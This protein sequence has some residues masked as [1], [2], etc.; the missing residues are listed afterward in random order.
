MG[1]WKIMR[2]WKIRKIEKFWFSLVCLV[3]GME[4]WEG[5]KLFCLV[6]EKNGRIENVVYINW[7]L[8]LYYNKI[9]KGL[10]SVKKWEYL[11][12][13]LP[14]SFFLLSFPLKLGGQ[15]F[16][17]PEGKFFTPLPFPLVFSLEPNKIK[18]YFSPYFSL[19]LFYPLCFHPNQTGPKV[20]E[21]NFPNLLLS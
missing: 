2:G 3:G 15:N 21:S 4:K 11:C 9:S 8:C 6:G 20:W 5:E 18:F 1:G 17:S 7:L 16:V 13:L 10:I 14:T 19:I 12:N